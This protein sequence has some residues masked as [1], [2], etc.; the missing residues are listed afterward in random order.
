MGLAL[1]LKSVASKCMGLS[2]TA[3]GGKTA[4]LYKGTKK[5]LIAGVR[6][7]A[8]TILP[9]VLLSQCRRASAAL[10]L[11]P[12]HNKAGFQVKVGKDQSC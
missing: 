10:L 5:I 11:L 12:P 9:T 3:G 8:F 2:A 6:T 1:R 4:N 7:I